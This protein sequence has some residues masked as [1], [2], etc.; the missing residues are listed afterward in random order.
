MVIIASLFSLLTTECSIPCP[1]LAS[2]K[3]NYDV[4]I[5]KPSAYPSLLLTDDEWSYIFD[6]VKNAFQTF[7][8][9]NFFAE[10]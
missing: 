1:Y 4:V 8:Y 6:N 9:V 10:N 3:S 2:S 7:T 5:W